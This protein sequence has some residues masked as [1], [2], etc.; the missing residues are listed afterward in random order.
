MICWD[1]HHKCSP[2]LVDLNTVVDVAFNFVLHKVFHEVCNGH[3][4]SSALQHPLNNA[5]INRV[6]SYTSMIIKTSSEGGRTGKEDIQMLSNNIANKDVITMHW[7]HF[8]G[9]SLNIFV[10][11]LVSNLFQKFEWPG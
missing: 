6:L 1:K 11:S 2:N 5:K 7:A 3:M 4:N 10:V 9:H 8:H